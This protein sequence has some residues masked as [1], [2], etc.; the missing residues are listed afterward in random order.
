MNARMHGDSIEHLLI[1]AVEQNPMLWLA[2][3]VLSL[4][5]PRASFHLASLWRADLSKADIV[6][7]LKIDE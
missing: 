3:S 1:G 5:Q 7:S 4:S 6:P 2:A